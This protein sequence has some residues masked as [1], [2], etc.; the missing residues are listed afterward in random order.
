MQL[1]CLCPADH[2]HPSDTEKKRE[3]RRKREIFRETLFESQQC[4]FG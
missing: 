3:F 1:C 2:S 4:H